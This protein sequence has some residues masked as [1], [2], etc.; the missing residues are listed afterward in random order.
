MIHW[1]VSHT[2]LE[3]TVLSSVSWTETS[4]FR[5]QYYQ[6]IYHFFKPVITMETPFNIPS[7]NDNS[8]D[9]LMNQVKE[10]A[11]FRMTP[12]KIYKTKILWKAYQYLVISTCRLYSQESTETFLQSQVITLDQLASEGKAC[13]CSDMLA[14]GLKEQVTGSRQPPKGQQA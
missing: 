14:H 9:I 10:P 12:N 5:A 7:S 11:K 8:S 3:T 2:D 4:T 13:N 6:Q 1:I